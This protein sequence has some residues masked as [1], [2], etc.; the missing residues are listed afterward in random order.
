MR[1]RAS[2]ISAVSA[3]SV[4]A[5]AND[6]RSKI[7]LM[8]EITL[9]AASGCSRTSTRASSSILV[10]CVGLCAYTKYWRL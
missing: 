9:P 8:G 10:A 4:S 3:S 6:P 5:V 1:G 7:L 2:V